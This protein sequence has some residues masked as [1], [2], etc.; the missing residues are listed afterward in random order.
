LIVIK[1]KITETKEKKG[2]VSISTGLD[3]LASILEIWNKWNVM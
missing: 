3:R 1:N 2:E